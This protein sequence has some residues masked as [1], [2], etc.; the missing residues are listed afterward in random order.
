MDPRKIQKEELERMRVLVAAAYAIELWG[1]HY[2]EQQAAWL[3]L[4]INQ[5]PEVADTST[6]RRNRRAGRVPYVAYGN[7]TV[8]Y[9]GCQLVDYL[10]F[11]EKAVLLWGGSDEGAQA[12]E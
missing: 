3:L 9:F 4:P 2:T 11:G 6:L 1:T 5:R 12:A 8:R 7:G 10:L